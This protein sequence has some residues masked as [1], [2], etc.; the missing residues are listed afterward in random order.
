[1]GVHIIARHLANTVERLFAAF[2]SG[3]AT[4]CGDVDCSQI[5]LVSPIRD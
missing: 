4:K 2:M 1:M 3:S 5:T